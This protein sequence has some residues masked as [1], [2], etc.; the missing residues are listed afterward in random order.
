METKDNYTA[1]HS[2]RVASY[3]VSLAKERAKIATTLENSGTVAL[4]A[5]A[6]KVGRARLLGISDPLK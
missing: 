3:A 6:A 1:G 2:L 4:A 5:G